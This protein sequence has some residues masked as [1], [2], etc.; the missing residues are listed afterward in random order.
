MS[1]KNSRKEPDSSVSTTQESKKLKQTDETIKI[2]KV[3]NKENML[4]YET[5]FNKQHQKHGF[6]TDYTIEATLEYTNN[7]INFMNYENIINLKKIVLFY[8]DQKFKEIL[9]EIYEL[10]SILLGR[11]LVNIKDKIKKLNIYNIPVCFI[12]KENN[13]YYG[14]IYYNTYGNY[15]VSP[16][17]KNFNNRVTDDLNDTDSVLIIINTLNK[18][19]LTNSEVI[20]KELN[21]RKI[22]SYF[23][24][25]KLDYNVNY[26]EVVEEI[27]LNF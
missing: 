8:T 21:N 16:S 5:S 3:Y 14:E 26:E 13:K 12:R 25:I 7:E 20:Y 18:K 23:K 11:D 1:L 6:E 15:E 24:I 27:T 4:I 9:K 2:E 10:E 17:K 22:L 19:I